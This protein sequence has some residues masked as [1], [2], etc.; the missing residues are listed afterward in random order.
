M[1]GFLSSAM[2]NTAIASVILYLYKLIVLQ[3]QGQLL[4]V[5]KTFFMTLRVKTSKMVRDY[6]GR[7]MLTDHSTIPVVTFFHAPSDPHSTILLQALKILITKYNIRILPKIVS[8]L[9]DNAI[10][11]HSIEYV[12]QWN[13]G[14]KDSTAV[15][16]VNGLQQLR[17]LDPPVI[18]VE[19][20]NVK[21]MKYDV[22]LSK[23]LEELFNTQ[24]S[25]LNG[26]TAGNS[27]EFLDIA[28]AAGKELFGR[29]DGPKTLDKETLS[30]RNKYFAPYMNMDV[31]DKTRQ[32]QI[33]A[34]NHQDLKDLGH[35]LAG[36]LYL[37]PDFYWGVD[38][39][40]HLEERLLELNLGRYRDQKPTFVQNYKLRALTIPNVQSLKVRPP[41]NKI[42]MYYS[43]RSPYSQLAVDRIY[44]LGKSWGIEVETKPVLPMVVSMICHIYIYYYYYLTLYILTIIRYICIYITFNTDAWITSK[45]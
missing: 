14:L 45:A 32:K 40:Y 25:S 3:P 6:Q 30:I 2:K 33:I 11:G 38:R 36:M 35:Y 10:A 8:P 16:K 28:I 15:A 24:D 20:F 37:K 26:L 9:R 12:T 17:S 4:T 29:K 23:I 39:L 7:T 44:N 43:F 5:L 27:M 1:K 19:D 18:N 13:W 42:V 21:A 41:T 31:H 22:L 34:T